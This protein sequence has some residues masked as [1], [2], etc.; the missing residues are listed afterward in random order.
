M[1][2]TAVLCWEQGGLVAV[3]NLLASL[4]VGQEIRI[5]LYERQ[6]RKQILLCQ[7][8]KVPLS[9][10]MQVHLQEGQGVQHQK[11][12]RLQEEAV[13]VTKICSA[14]SCSP[15]EVGKALSVLGAAMYKDDTGG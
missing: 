13:P 14:N 5:L 15:V 3:Q 2:V 8:L 11:S 10:E 12:C 4:L 1:P 7:L 9:V 6:Q